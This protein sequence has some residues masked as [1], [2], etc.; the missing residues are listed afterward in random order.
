MAQRR[1]DIVVL[2]IN[3]PGEDGLSLCLRLRNAGGPPVIM[4]TAKGE[5][6]D[7]ILGLE[8]GADDYLPKPFNPRELLARIKAVLRRAHSLP[9]QPER[10]SAR[11]L[12]FDGW[13]FDVARRELVGEDGVAVPL[14]TGEFLLL[15]VLVRRPGMVLTRDQLMDKAMGADVFVTDRAIDVHVTAIRKKLGDA[16]WLVHTV[17]GVGYRLQ[18][19]NA[20]V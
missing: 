11:R 15:S 6:V 5:D 18:E 17:R 19:E 3:L 2:D 20:E 13:T 7:R 8:M 9:P 1:P 14:S 10:P 4:V 16:N 12:R